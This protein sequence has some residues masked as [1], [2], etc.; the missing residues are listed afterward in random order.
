MSLP[1]LE[2]NGV[3][4]HILPG[5]DLGLSSTLSTSATDS[6]TNFTTGVPAS[7]IVLCRLNSGAAT[8]NVSVNSGTPSYPANQLVMTGTSRQFQKV[9]TDSSNL[10][11]GIQQVCVTNAGF[12][13][14]A[15]LACYEL[16]PGED[17]FNIRSG[18]LAVANQYTG[19]GSGVMNIFF[20]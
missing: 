18:S 15:V 11:C 20:A 14:M 5:I 17:W 2:Q 3:Y 16:T 9:D 7:V 8:V 10:F 1:K 6:G 12:E 13:E 19:D 4:T